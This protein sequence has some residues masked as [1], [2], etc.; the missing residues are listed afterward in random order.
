LKNHH[1]VD[2]GIVQDA[3]NLSSN[4]LPNNYKANPMIL[5]ECPIID[6]NIPEI[7][8]TALILEEVSIRAMNHKNMKSLPEP[9][10]FVLQPIENLLS[11]EQLKHLVI[12]SQ[13]QHEYQGRYV[14]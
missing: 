11:L 6:A 7:K 10:P 4:N 12:S 14:I 13:Q 9:E 2:K 3:T 5:E 8:L 1:H